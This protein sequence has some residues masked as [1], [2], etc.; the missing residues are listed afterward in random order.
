M[1]QSMR[2]EHLRGAVTAGRGILGNNSQW[3]RPTHCS[4][5][6]SS[7][8]WVKGRVL[9]SMMLILTLC[10]CVHAAE[11]VGTSTPEIESLFND[12]ESWASGDV[13]ITGTHSSREVFS[14]NMRV[15][16]DEGFRKVRCDYRMPGREVRVARDGR[17]SLLY[18][19]GSRVVVK[20]VPDRKWSVPHSSPFDVRIVGFTTYS[21][22]HTREPFP[23]V[24][25]LIRS[26]AVDLVEIEPTELHRVEWV[27]A[28]TGTE[29][30]RRKLWCDPRMRFAP[31]RMEFWIE[32]LANGQVV[33]RARALQAA[34][35]YRMIDDRW[36][37]A[38]W[39]V[40]NNGSGIDWQFDWHSFNEPIPASMFQIEGMDLPAGTMVENRTLGTSI[41]ESWIGGEPLS[42]SKRP[43]PHTWRHS[44]WLIIGNAC[45]LIAIASVWLYRRFRVRHAR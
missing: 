28:P 26:Q 19:V 4:M 27:L 31:V 16:F 22:A 37:P 8:Q 24:T 20:D 38:K 15:V 5:L 30:A 35:E 23:E 29:R 41:V 6:A 44:F 1:E 3:P 11:Y 17:Q 43:S 18:V 14:E 7:T 33:G 9:A 12:R 36:L 2:G 42:G 13:T 21:S 10:Q 32:T 45:V 25:A 40:E 34:A 39:H